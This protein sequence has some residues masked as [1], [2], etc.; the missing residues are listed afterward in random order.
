[1]KP[2]LR[3][4]EEIAPVRIPVIVRNRMTKVNKVEIQDL[5]QSLKEMALD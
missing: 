5:D 3:N 1:M 4:M 2:P